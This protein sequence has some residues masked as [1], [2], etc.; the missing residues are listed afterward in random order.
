MLI[1][2]PHAIRNIF[3]GNDKAKNVSNVF[4]LNDLP[5]QIRP[6][7]EF[8]DKALLTCLYLRLTLFDAFI[9][10]IWLCS[11]GFVTGNVKSF[12]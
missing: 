7:R 11:S 5:A 6:N 1:L 10:E 12:T 9:S 8:H 2:Q 3:I 4:E